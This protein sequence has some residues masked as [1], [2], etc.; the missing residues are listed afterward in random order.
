M[1]DVV[2]VEPVLAPK[3]IFVTGIHIDLWQMHSYLPKNDSQKRLSNWEEFD[4]VFGTSC[5]YFSLI[6]EPV[7]LPNNFLT[8]VCWRSMT[9]KKYY[10]RIIDKERLLFWDKCSLDEWNALF[11]STLGRVK[12]LCNNGWTCTGPK[13]NIC[14][15]NLYWSLKNAL[16][17]I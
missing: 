16:V 8:R 15:R 7:L 5:N 13:E 2:M 6:V 4:L 12:P 3:N 9:Q 14:D 17:F 1:T 11:F 10:L